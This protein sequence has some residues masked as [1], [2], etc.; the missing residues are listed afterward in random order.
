V[1]DGAEVTT[2]GRPFQM[3]APAIGKALAAT[4]DRRYDGKVSCLVDA[5]LSRRRVEAHRWHGWTATPGKTARC[6]AE[7]GTSGQL[8]WR[9]FVLGRA[10][11]EGWSTRLWCVQTVLCC[12]WAVLQHF[13]P[14]VDVGWQTD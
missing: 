4:V 6:R 11:S 14:I 3:R 10:A 8:F 5:D 13:G 9:R 1:S 12:R 7:L 2:G